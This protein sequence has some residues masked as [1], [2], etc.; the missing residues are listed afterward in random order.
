VHG[1]LS[2]NIGETLQETRHVGCRKGNSNAKARL[3]QDAPD[4]IACTMQPT[5][6]KTALAIRRARNVD[7]SLLA[8]S[9]DN[10]GNFYLSRGNAK[11]TTENDH[12]TEM[13]VSANEDSR[14]A[15][16]IGS[17]LVLATRQQIGQM[18]DAEASG[19]VIAA[20]ERLQTT[21]ALRPQGAAIVSLKPD[22]R[23][24]GEL[25]LGVSKLTR[26][27]DGSRELLEQQPIR[28]A[29]DRLPPTVGF[30]EFRAYGIYSE[31]RS[32]IGNFGLL[33]SLIGGGEAEK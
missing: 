24:A 15:A 25:L 26:V 32:A 29:L 11:V 16:F 28:Q 17:F 12:G 18:I 4:T 2:M 31:T 8:T 19:N 13:L 21:I 30:T 10:L 27:T 23:R 22:A 3:P 33:A 6:L 1:E 20:D 7:P 5:M 9:L 14:A